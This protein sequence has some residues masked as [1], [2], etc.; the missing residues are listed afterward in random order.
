MNELKEHATDDDADI[1]YF[2]T[3]EDQLVSK[4]NEDWNTTLVKSLGD[5]VELISTG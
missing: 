1:I 4:C 2:E 5:I 3:K